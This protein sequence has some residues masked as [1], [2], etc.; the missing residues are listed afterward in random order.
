MNTLALRSKQKYWRLF[1]FCLLCLAVAFATTLADAAPVQSAPTLREFWV[2]DLSVMPPAFR[3]TTATLR[4]SGNRTLIYVEDKFFGHE[5]TADYVTRLEYQLERSVPSGA[6]ITDTGIVPLEERIFG[7]L[8]TKIAKDDRLVVLFAAL[9]QY[10]DVQF[11]GFFNLYDQ[12]P[13]SEAMQKYQQ[14]SNE[15]NVIYLNGFRKSETYTTG[16]IA[17]ELQHLLASGTTE[18]SRESWL[19]E[20]LAE[21]AMLLTGFFSDQDHVDK[22]L[23]E[24]GKYPLVTSGYVQYGPQ[25]LFSS[26]L[27][28][29]LPSARDMTAIASLNRV[30]LGGRDAVEKLYQDLTEAPLS[31]DAIFS[32]F[33]SY[34][35]EQSAGGA[36]LPNSWRHSPAIHV[37]QIA[38]FFTYQAGSGELTGELAPYSFVAVDLAQELSP[39]AEIQ[40]TRIPPSPGQTNASG[41]AR[42]ASVLWKPV[43]KT[44]I[45]IYAVGCDPGEKP[46]D[47]QFRLRILDQPSLLPAS[48]FKL[49]R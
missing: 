26:F 10:K 31:F 9:G 17:H 12:L 4:A 13:E 45:A 24:T 29:S 47:V 43:N 11:D 40:V 30:E 21:G 42:D 19:S 7:P 28:D 36:A 1:F 14:H 33:V 48:P 41:C 18:V 15:A 16:V 35:F 3:K 25:L 20:S 27:A 23:S 5:I 37:L 2:W 39:S 34:V 22:Y 38:P 46:E 6:Y 32:N 49:L 44:R 8:P